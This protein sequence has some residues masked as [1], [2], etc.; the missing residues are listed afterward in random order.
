MGLPCNVPAGVQ[1]DSVARALP[2][3]LLLQV[4]LWQ[5]EARSNPRLRNANYLQLGR[6]WQ[7]QPL[8]KPR[9]SSYHHLLLDREQGWENVHKDEEKNPAGTAGL[10]TL[11]VRK[12]YF[13]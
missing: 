5:H 9:K 12:E 11:L 8:Q 1:G 4:Q 3:L 10:P 2:V 13:I 7:Q 6:S